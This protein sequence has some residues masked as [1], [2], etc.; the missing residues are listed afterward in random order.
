MEGQQSL[1]LPWRSFSCW[2][3]EHFTFSFAYKGCEY[4]I[5]DY[6]QP[7][8]LK[9]YPRYVTKNCWRSVDAHFH[10]GAGSMLLALLPIWAADTLFMTTCNLSPRRLP[11]THDEESLM[12]LWCS[13]S[14]WGR[15]RFTVSFAYK[16]SQYFV[17]DNWQP[18][19]PQIT[20]DTLPRIIDALLTLILPQEYPHHTII[21]SGV[22]YHSRWF[23]SLSKVYIGFFLITRLCCN[24]T[25][26]YI[27]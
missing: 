8:A 23:G 1:T 19:A 12:L 24:N 14:W 6:V 3:R 20:H 11:M 7:I 17:Y 10:D 16:G 21:W 22:V 2:G 15:E 13:F 26:K 5:S 4:F 27:H 25:Y 18:I 9:D